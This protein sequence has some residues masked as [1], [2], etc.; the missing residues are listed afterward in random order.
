MFNSRG[1]PGP[2]G[3]PGSAAPELTK[4]KKLRVETELIKNFELN[5]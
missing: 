2:P 5:L 4:T 1:G 3:P